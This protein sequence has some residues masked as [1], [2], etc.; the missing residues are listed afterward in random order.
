MNIDELLITHYCEPGKTPLHSIT[1]LPREEAFHL[2]EE[3]SKN[4]RSER[5]RFGPDF[6][7]YY[8]KRMMAENWLYHSFKASG[9]LPQNEHPIYFVLCE[10]ERLHQWFG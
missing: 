7:G 4:C 5:N 2:A 8:P 3:L 6:T 10:S 1:R 9:G